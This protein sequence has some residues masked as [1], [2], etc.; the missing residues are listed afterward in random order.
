MNR[1]LSGK[2][3]E[4]LSRD[5]VWIEFIDPIEKSNQ[6][7]EN[8]PTDIVRSYSS[9]ILVSGASLR[10]TNIKHNIIHFF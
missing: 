4:I 8:H 9:N 10:L 5:H 1:P 7:I 6:F 3:R 2:Y